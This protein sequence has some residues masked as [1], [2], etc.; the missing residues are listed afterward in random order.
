M[1]EFLQQLSAPPITSWM[2]H[3]SRLWHN[4]QGHSRSL[5]ACGCS[6]KDRMSTVFSLLQ[7]L[8]LFA[9]QMYI[10]S[11]A[12]HHHRDRAGL[13]ALQW[14][15]NTSL[16]LLYLL[17]LCSDGIFQT[18]MLYDEKPNTGTKMLY[19]LSHFFKTS[20]KEN[21]ALGH[22]KTYCNSP[23]LLI[24]LDNLWQSLLVLRSQETAVTLLIFS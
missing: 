15:F 3:N 13:V 22:C 1:T 6:S 7:S 12:V 8:D 17:R 19:N 10:I 5:C 20:W 23:R 14:A 4:L 16:C 9:H 21:V 18:D 11:M 2:K 24:F